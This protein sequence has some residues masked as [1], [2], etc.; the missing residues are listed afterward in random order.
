MKGGIYNVESQT[1]C[2]PMRA[3]WLETNRL[4]RRSAIRGGRYLRSRFRTRCSTRHYEAPK[5]KEDA[6]LR[7]LFFFLREISK[8]F[9]GE[10]LL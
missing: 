6:R 2:G 5:V 3:Y 8:V 1:D 4:L 7:G 9:Y 10:L